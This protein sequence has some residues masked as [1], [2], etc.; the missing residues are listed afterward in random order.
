MTIQEG[1][2]VEIA[3]AK[4]SL[5]LQK[6]NDRLLLLSYG[7]KGSAINKPKDLT[8]WVGND[9]MEVLSSF[10]GIDYREPLVE[11]CDPRGYFSYRFHPISLLKSGGDLTNGGMPYAKNRQQN[12]ILSYLD[13]TQTVLIKQR[14]GIFADSDVLS[15]SLEIINQGQ[16]SLFVRR[17]FS[18]QLD[19]P[20]SAS[21][22]TTFNG[23]WGRERKPVVHHL[24]NGTF[25]FESRCGISSSYVNPFF[26]VK[27]GKN[28]YGF[29]LIYSGNH[30][31]IVASSYNGTTR[32][33]SGMND[34]MENIEIKPGASF[35][36][37]EAVFTCGSSLDE[38]MQ[39]MQNFVRG[40][41]L[42]KSPLHH[43]IV[44]NAWESLEFGLDKNNWP[45]LAVLASQA[46]A[47]TFVFDDGW[48]GERSDT[49]TSLGDWYLNTAKIGASFAAIRQTLAAS[50]LALGLWIEPEMVS[51]RS[52][53]YQDHPDFVLKRDGMTP[54]LCRDQLVLDLANPACVKAIHASLS[55]L[56]RES[57]VS[58]LKWDFNRL[59][60][61]VASSACLGGE[62]FHR[63]ILGFY[64]LA[65]ELREENPGLFFEGC[66][67]GGARFDL[68]SLSYFPQIWTSDNTDARDRLAIQEGTAIAYPLSC[69]S[70]HVS[71]S[72]NLLSKRPTS[73]EDRINVA[74]FGDFGFECDLRK[75]TPA[76][77]VRLRE[78]SRYYRE[79]EALIREGSF[80]LLSD[81]F[82]ESVCNWLLLQGDQGLLLA[83][84][85]DGSPNEKIKIPYL[86]DDV[87]YEFVRREVSNLPKLPPLILSG[88]EAKTKGL[89]LSD[90]CSESDRGDNPGSISSQVYA[91]R[92]HLD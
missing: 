56:I 66:A 86:E 64:R 57:G 84:V 8:E 4:T 28:Y 87:V 3:T 39:S 50:H 46:G 59:L 29:N 10:G 82:D 60:S 25:S 6:L 48:F 27:Q 62:Y 5:F 70:N 44:F 61:D 71:C 9:L 30:K 81:P 31:E 45:Q 21:E 58:Y 73:L 52:H 22:I 67:S 92:R 12:V 65:S 51:P 7:K 77:M 42:P 54:L 90:F 14:Y 35:V 26:L 11:I 32:V 91:I 78:G 55:R 69:L 38:V 37:P 18:L 68:G 85:L 24:E 16:T 23:A 20:V 13:E 74:L 47:D 83:C 43:P 72:P 33:L 53:F 40:H 80:H 17:A 36:T 34:F 1:D 88:K 19:F 76:E 2:Q 89:V 41:I 15:T 63:F 49:K 75:Q 79:H